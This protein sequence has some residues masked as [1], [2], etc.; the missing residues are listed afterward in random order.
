MAETTGIAWTDHTFNPWW[1]CTRVSAGCRN[2]YAETFAKRTGHAVWGTSAERRTFG[3][4]HWNEPLRWNRKASA[5]GVQRRVFCASMADVF[6]DHP[7]VAGERRRLWD[8][9]G[10]TTWLDWQLLTKRPENVA[11]MVPAEWLSDFPGWPENVWIGTTV[12]D[13]AAADARVPILAAL[14]AP[15]RFLSCEPLIGPVDLSA[16]L[17]IEWMDAL[18]L[19]GQP[20]SFRGEGGWGAEMLASLAGY[21]PTVDWIIAGGESGPGHR[22]LD[23]DH[24]RDL[25]DQADAAGVP[26]FFKQHGG[27]RPTSGGSLLDGETRVEFPATNGAASLA[28][29]G[30]NTGRGDHR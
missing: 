26:F 3:E 17:G 22:P 6:E 27:A 1:G 4:K 7:D 21:A 29:M 28:P 24:A 15:V 18:R 20:M 30:L 19:P 23:V 25:R 8:L 16:W 12:E 9:I 2:C 5:E 11:G 13:Q 14:P 10:E